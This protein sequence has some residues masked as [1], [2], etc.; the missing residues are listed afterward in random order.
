MILTVMVMIEYLGSPSKRRGKQDQNRQSKVYPQ[1]KDF[2]A[3]QSLQFLRILR[4]LRSDNCAADGRDHFPG[5]DRADHDHDNAQQMFDQ[6]GQRPL[7]AGREKAIIMRVDAHLE[8]T[9]K[10]QQAHAE[11]GNRLEPPLHRFDED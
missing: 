11:P 8:Q 2:P 1:E 3:P 5:L 6:D 10:D 4:F 7:R 9:R